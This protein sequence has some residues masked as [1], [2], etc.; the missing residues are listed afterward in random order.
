MKFYQPDALSGFFVELV[1]G[2]QL[3]Y[4]IPVSFNLLNLESLILCLKI[5]GKTALNLSKKI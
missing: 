5:Y 4:Q 2:Q 3:T 1:Q